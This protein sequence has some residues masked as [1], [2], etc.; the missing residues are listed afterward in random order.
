MDLFLIEIQY[1]FYRSFKFD[2]LYIV[3][4]VTIK[5]N[6]HWMYIHA[7]FLPIAASLFRFISAFFGT[8]GKKLIVGFGMLM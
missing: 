8:I 7:S 6:S 3:V 4:I 1:H 2:I 5:I